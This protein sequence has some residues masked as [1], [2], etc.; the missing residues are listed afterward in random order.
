M[1]I[2]VNAISEAELKL[3]IVRNPLIVT[4][5]ITFMEAIAQMSGVRSS[6]SVAQ[7]TGSQQDIL[8]IE[9]RSSCVLVVENNQLVG[10]FT[11]R[12]VVKLSAQKRNL[13]NLAIADVMTHPVVTLRESEFTN[14]FFAVNLLQHHHIR[15]LPVVDEQN[16]LV[17]LLTH[18]SLRQTSR[19]ADLLRLRLV[20][21]VMTSNVICAAADVSILADRSIDGRKPR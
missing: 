8:Q 13:E 15:H 14:I 11:E 9:A 17:G 12:D 5:N 18:E 7:T 21:E 4:A 2:S 6:C 1:L 10:I 19:P 20:N 3:A 16:Q